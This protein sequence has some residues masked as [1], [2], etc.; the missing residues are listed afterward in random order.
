MASCLA[1]FSLVSAAGPTSF[2]AALIRLTTSADRSIRHRSVVSSTG[3]NSAPHR[4][5]SWYLARASTSLPDAC[6][7]RPS[8]MHFLAFTL[9]TST[10]GGA[11]IGAGGGTGFVGTIGAA[12]TGMLGA[13]GMAM[14][15][16]GI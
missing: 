5:A 14:G 6:K 7:A 15:D 1:W 13:T 2:M 3:P 9:A 4:W 12:A 8:V 16:G 11:G 10:V